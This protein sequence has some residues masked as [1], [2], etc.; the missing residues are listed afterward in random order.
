MKQINSEVKKLYENIAKYSNSDIAS[1]IAFGMELPFSPTQTEKNE[2]VKYIISGLEKEFDEQTIKSIRMGCYCNGN[3][4]L[5]ESKKFIKS[6]Y[7]DSASIEKFVDKMNEYGVGLY[8][9]DRY[10][11]IK[12]SSCPCRMIESVTVLP[13]KTWCYC[14]V[15]YNK[16]IFEYVFNCKVDIEL[17][18]SIKMGNKHCLMKIIPLCENKINV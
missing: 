14:T 2:W 10:L 13:T 3:G 12:Y 1:K 9:K 16:E 7:D 18:E 15:G 4:H 8:L 6:I 5:D 17:L 11:F